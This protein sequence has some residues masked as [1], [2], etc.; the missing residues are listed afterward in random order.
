[1]IEGGE[2]LLAVVGMTPVIS[3]EIEPITKEQ[4]RRVMFIERDIDDAVRDLVHGKPPSVRDVRSIDYMQTLTDLSTPY[5][6]HQVEAMLNELPP[7]FDSAGPFLMLA[8]R[9]FEFLGSKLPRQVKKDLTGA[10]HIEPPQRLVERFVSLLEVLDDPLQTLRLAANAQLLTPQ[11]EALDV[12]FPG[13]TDY[14]RKSLARQI[15]DARG[16]DADFQLPYAADTGAQKLLGADLTSPVLRKILQAPA[17]AVAQS[18]DNA[19]AGDA[20]LPEQQMTRVQ[21]TDNLDVG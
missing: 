1:M 10:Q 6:Q 13:V 3:H 17:P 5:D 4:W 11:I 2:A 9:A 18:K 12:V 16:E 21:R 7:W 20:K 14:M 19:G 15:G 8:H